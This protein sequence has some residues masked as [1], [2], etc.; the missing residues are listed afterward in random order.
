MTAMLDQ[1]H[2]PRTDFQGQPGDPLRGR[3]RIDPIKA[4]WVTM[5]LTLGTVGAAL[6]ITPSAVIIFVV[7]TGLTLCLG[8]SLGM[9]RRFIHGSFQCPKWLEY[10]LV[11]LGVLVGLAGPLGMLRTHD[12]RDW[13]QRQDRCH[14]YFAHRQPW[15][16]DLF[17]QVICRIDLDRPPELR[18]EAE[19]ARDQVY[20]WM[21]H[22]WMAQQLPW[23]LALWFGG[24]WAW[25][26]WGIGTRVS[27]SILGHWLIGYFAHNRGHQDWHVAGA[28][29]QG[30]NVS[31]TALLTMG[32][33]WHNN[34]HGY[35]RS[36]RLGILPGQWDPGWWV[37]LLLQR[38]GLAWDI[39]LAS[40]DARRVVRMGQGTDGLGNR[41][42]PS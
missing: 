20:R 10:V 21:E 26:C 32:E 25:V 36:A 41:A 4:L 15:W 13:A 16:R 42:V 3:V 31:F 40:P 14:D 19:I 7:F 28:S 1:Y 35:P 30:H 18:L 39:L 8:H 27:V 33:C 38:L 24:G 29:V 17:W 9:H 34:H 37:L 2:N 5:M 6:T 22:T 12:T 11:H 23:A